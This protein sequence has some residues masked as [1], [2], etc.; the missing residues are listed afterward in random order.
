[1]PRLSGSGRRDSTVDVDSVTASDPERLASRQPACDYQY[2][3]REGFTH[4]SEHSTGGF[5]GTLAALFFAA[6]VFGG[7]VPFLFLGPVVV[8]AGAS[9]LGRGVRLASGWHARDRLGW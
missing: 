2:D 8:V 1:M 5:T 6:F 7:I 4:S 9:V 3:V